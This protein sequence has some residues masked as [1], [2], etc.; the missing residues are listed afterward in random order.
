MKIKTFYAN[1]FYGNKKES[2]IKNN[3]KKNNDN[4]AINKDIKDKHQKKSNNYLKP[5]EPYVSKKAMDDALM[6]LFLK[7]NKMI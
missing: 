7:H 5:E 6:I 2:N 1:S 3:F 4:E